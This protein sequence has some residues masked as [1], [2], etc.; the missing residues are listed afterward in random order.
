MV[1]LTG[2]VLGLADCYMF[3]NSARLTDIMLIA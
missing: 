2:G 1:R 3:R